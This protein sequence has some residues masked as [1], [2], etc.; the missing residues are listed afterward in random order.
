MRICVLVNSGGGAVAKLGG[1]DAARETLSAAMERLQPV[2]GDLVLASG[3]DFAAC[4]RRACD[5]AKRGEYDAIVAAGGDGSIGTVAALIADTGI[6]LGVLPLGTLNHFARDLGIPIDIEGAFATVAAG[7]IARVDLAEVNGRIF[8][9]NSSI[10]IYPDMV[11]EREMR[12]AGRSRLIA[13]PLAFLRALWRFPRRRLRIVAA[14]RAAVHR[15]PCLFVGNNEYQLD[16]LRMGK[17]PRLDGGDLCVYVA[18]AMS[19]W[20][21][22]WLALRTALGGPAATPDLEMLRTPSLD[23]LSRRRRLRVSL[24]GEIARLRPPLRYR[25]RRAALLVFAPPPEADAMA[26]GEPARPCRTSS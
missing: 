3:A 10:G 8:V 12:F 14:G 4:A 15:T 21:M 16:L 18:Q 23:V 2:V 22:F 13:T 6:P 11:V 7:A 5:A 20:G 1:P 25:S 9:N 17:R 24:D 26:A 19:R